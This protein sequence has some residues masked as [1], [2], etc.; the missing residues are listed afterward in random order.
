MINVGSNQK[1]SIIDTGPYS[2]R[3]TSKGALLAETAQVVSALASGLSLDD[4]RRKIMD[5]SL[6]RQP[7]RATRRRIWHAL[8]H[9]FFARRMDWIA[10]ALKDA[11]AAGT[12]SREFIS[13]VY[14]H[15]ALSD[16]LTYDVITD[17]IWERWT[18]HRLLVSRADVLSFLDKMTSAQPQIGRWSESSRLKL[19]GGVLTALRD[20]GVLEGTQKKRLVQPVLPL[21]T[22]EHLLRI[23]IM[24]GVMGKDVV[25]HPA[26]RLFLCA[27]HDVADALSRLAMLRRIGFER[28]GSTV[29]LHTP[30]EWR[31]SP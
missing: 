11:F 2:A 3:N 24:E 12:R 22:A 25:D 19:A 27:P 29:V 4:T 28:A 17:L 10:A 16:H 13:I 6:L 7:T 21:Q 8:H 14:L 18:E 26:W 30:A 15:Y 9:R 20:F 1:P 23:L 31:D 5:G